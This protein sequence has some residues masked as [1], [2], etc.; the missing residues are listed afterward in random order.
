M[1]KCFTWSLGIICGVSLVF[2]LL[3]STLAYVSYDVGYILKSYEKYNTLERIPVSSYDLEKV[4]VHL[5]DYLKDEHDDLHILAN[6]NEETAPFYNEREIA[7]MVDVKNLFVLLN[8]LIVATLLVST[9]II[10]FFSRKKEYEILCKSII[11]SV[12]LFVAIFG[13]GVF[14][15]S[16]DFTKAFIIFHEIFFTNDLWILDYSKDYLLNMVPEA[17][18]VDISARIAFIFTICLALLLIFSIIVSR[19]VNKSKISV[20]S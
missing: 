12:L 15:I 6:I 13:F 11:L 19:A 17:F 20:K 5:I 18:F 14:V 1:Y 10:C 4:T 9:V 2:F 8:N 16:Q 3:F 7:H